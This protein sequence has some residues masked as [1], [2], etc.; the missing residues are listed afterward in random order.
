MGWRFPLRFGGRDTTLE[1]EHQ[2]LLD[3][4]APGWDTSAGTELREEAFV[5]ALAVTMVWRIN[6]RVANQLNPLKM[7]ENLP[8]WETACSL[9]PTGTDT[10][11]ARRA[12]L[13][14]KLRGLTGNSVADLTAATES[15]LGEAFDAV[16]T[17]DPDDWVTYWPGLNPGPPGYEFASNRATIGVRMLKDRLTEGEFRRLRAKLIDLLDQMRPAWMTFVTGV[18][19]GWVCN[20]GVVGQ[21]VI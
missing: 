9:R 19:S 20:V 17:V 4:L 16:V 12:T 10:D 7:L 11:P 2:A 6:R 3:A 18:G 1:A 15:A 8:V 14:A 21:T 13:S 5:D